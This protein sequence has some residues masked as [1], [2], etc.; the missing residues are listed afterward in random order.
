MLEI[1]AAVLTVGAMLYHVGSLSL[2][3]IGYIGIGLIVLCLIIFRSRQGIIAGLIAGSIL[4]LGALSMWRVDVPLNEKIFGN[5]AFDARVVSVDRRLER[6]NVIVVDTEYEHK[7]QLVVRDRVLVLPGDRVAVRGEVERPQGFTTDTGR[8]FEYAQYLQSKGIV[9]LVQN[10]IIGPVTD[11][12]F[13]I[14]R[15]PTRIR[16]AIADIFSKHVS[17]PFDGVLAGIVVGYQ[18]GLPSSIQD[19]FRNTGVL[20]VLV[21]SG[22]N[23][24]LLAG[25]LAILLR[26]LPFRMRNIVTIVAIILLVLISGAGV[27]SVRAGIMGGI[28][29]LAGLSI[30]TY[31]AI[32]ALTL[33]YLIFFFVSPTTVFVDP[34]FHLSFLATLFMIL[35]LP[36][37]E[38]LFG[39]IPETRHIN[40]RELLMLAVSAPLFMLPYMMYFSGMFPLVSPVAN[41]LFAVVTP[42]L[43]IGGIVLMLLSWV[44]PLAN[45]IGMLLSGLGNFVLWF[46][47]WCDTFYIWQTPSIS[48]WGVSLVYVVVIGIIFRRELMLFV[49]QRYRVLRPPS[50]Q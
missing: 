5:R 3:T 18:G 33:A 37:V 23:I 6:T 43:M 12:E 29:V 35:V 22:Y 14:T 19:L 32:R 26:G 25:F 49:S 27:A 11:T 40:L 30:R 34:G 38:T 20:H 13:A 45:V 28:A 48:W 16:Y 50:S 31:N 42:I 21:L 8:V 2:C 39:W 7:L 44:I 15:I 36:K 1:G 41:I 24:T 9:G 17:F 46:L 47:R 4:L 10:P